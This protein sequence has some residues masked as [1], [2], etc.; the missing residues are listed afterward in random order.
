VPYNE[1]G[2]PCP[3]AGWIEHLDQ[4]C[5]LLDNYMTGL[6]DKFKET[7]AGSGACGDGTGY[8]K[9]DELSRKRDHV[10]LIGSKGL[11]IS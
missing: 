6:W 4:L 8:V 1:Q 11:Q 7:D 3:F 2:Y 9:P 10:K 5:P